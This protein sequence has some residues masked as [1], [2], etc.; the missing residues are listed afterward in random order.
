MFTRLID[1]LDGHWGKV[2]GVVLGLLFGWFAISYGFWR[3]LFVALMVAFG[4]YIG[5]QVDERTDWEKLWDRFR[6]GH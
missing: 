3:A 6:R 1:I 4:Y 5:K 2:G